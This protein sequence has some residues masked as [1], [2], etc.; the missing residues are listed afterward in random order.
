MRG[1]LTGEPVHIFWIISSVAHKPS[2]WSKS[3]GYVPNMTLSSTALGHFTL[4]GIHMTSGDKPLEPCLGVRRDM[5]PG[6]T[7][8][9]CTGE[10]GCDVSKQ[11]NQPNKAACRALGMRP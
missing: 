9:V 3:P 2:G 1:R 6:K 5:S 8:L 10:T 4:C 7:S 11:T